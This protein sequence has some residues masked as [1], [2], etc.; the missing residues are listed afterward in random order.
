MEQKGTKRTG[1]NGSKKEQKEPVPMVPNGS[2]KG[3]KRT[4]PNGSVKKER[5]E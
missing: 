2:K 4:G 5:I 3:T 1:P